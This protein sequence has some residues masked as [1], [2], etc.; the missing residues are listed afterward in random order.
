MDGSNCFDQYGTMNAVSLLQGPTITS[1]IMGGN[2]FCNPPSPHALRD[3]NQFAVESII[4]LGKISK[5]S[6]TWLKYRANSVETLSLTFCFCLLLTH[7]CN[8]L[9]PKSGLEMNT[10]NLLFSECQQHNDLIR[11]L[12]K[13]MTQWWTFSF[14]KHHKWPA[15]HTSSVV[16]LN[17]KQLQWWRSRHCVELHQL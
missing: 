13:R 14:T 9:P 11:E 10:R 15:T 6:P 8:S 5:I 4:S 3:A 2:W 1:L 7:L 16:H 12:V 17:D